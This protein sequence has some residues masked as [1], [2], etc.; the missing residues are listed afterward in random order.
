MPSAISRCG[1]SPS[2]EGCTRAG[3]R[4]SEVVTPTRGR[5]RAPVL[6]RRGGRVCRAVARFAW[7]V[8]TWRVAC[9]DRRTD[10]FDIRTK[11]GRLDSTRGRSE[12]GVRGRPASLDGGGAGGRCEGGDG[13][14]QAVGFFA[15]VVGDDADADRAAAVAEAK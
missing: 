14:E 8:A 2:A 15:R 5:R 9:R 11:I 6:V 10:A 1:G 13:F 12:A 7:K 4:I 3:R